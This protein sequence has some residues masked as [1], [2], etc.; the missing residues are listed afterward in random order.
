MG[1][2]PVIDTILQNSLNLHPTAACIIY[3][4]TLTIKYR[5][6]CFKSIRKRCRFNVF[7]SA[8]CLWKGGCG[9]PHSRQVFEILWNVRRQRGPPRYSKPVPTQGGRAGRRRRKAL[10]PASGQGSL[11]CRAPPPKPGPTAWGVSCKRSSIF[12]QNILLICQK[13]VIFEEIWAIYLSSGKEVKFLEGELGQEAWLHAIKSCDCS[14]SRDRCYL[15][16]AIFISYL[17]KQKFHHWY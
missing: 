11:V 2:L 12:K 6:C 16:K 9:P 17:A 3:K 13:Q 5:G 15:Q 14:K 4:G 8:I 1:K 7:P 10:Q